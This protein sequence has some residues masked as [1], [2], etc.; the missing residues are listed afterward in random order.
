MNSCVLQ[1][2]ASVEII[3]LAN[4]NHVDMVLS[5]DSIDPDESGASVQGATNFQLLRR[6]LQPV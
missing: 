2:K 5:D 6:C 4:K 1:G 3:E